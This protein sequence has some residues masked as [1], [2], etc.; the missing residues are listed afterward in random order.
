MINPRD[1]QELTTLLKCDAGLRNNMLKHGLAQRLVNGDFIL[2]P[3]G[4]AEMAERDR[5]VAG[6]NVVE[7]WSRRNA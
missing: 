6:F 4:E 1:Q 7:E 5:H 3:K 2:T